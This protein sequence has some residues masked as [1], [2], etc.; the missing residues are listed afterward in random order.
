MLGDPPSGRAEHADR[1]RLVEHQPGVVP[2][3]DLDQTRQIGDVSVH[4]VKTLGDDQ[5]PAHGAA[6]PGEELLEMIEVVVTESHQRCMRQARPD[7]GAVVHEL[8]REDQVLAFEQ[9]ADKG[10]V[11]EVA[12]HERKRVVDVE[13]RCQVA[14]ERAVDRSLPADQTRGARADA[15]GHDHV[16]CR[17]LDAQVALQAE[18]VVVCKAD[19]VPVL[20][21]RCRMYSIER[22]QV[23]R[24]ERRAPDLIRAV[25]ADEILSDA[26]Q[27][28]SCM[29]ADAIVDGVDAGSTGTKL[30]KPRD[31]LFTPAPWGPSRTVWSRSAA[32]PNV[33]L[34]EL[35]VTCNRRMLVSGCITILVGQRL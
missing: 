26:P 6:S 7:D 32:S 8:V 2:L 1:M 27:A 35:S 23:G 9:V 30:S 22:Q 31:V 21:A 4:A 10:D 5:H 33:S 12:A 18:I 29:K 13:K 16:A 14:L 17:L 15:A 25:F 34:R 28:R 20:G 11:G 19:E 3:L 24:V